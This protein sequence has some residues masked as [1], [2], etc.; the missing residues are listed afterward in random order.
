MLTLRPDPVGFFANRIKAAFSFRRV[1]CAVAGFSISGLGA[2]AL[3]GEAVANG[4]FSSTSGWTPFIYYSNYN[5]NPSPYA[6][7]SNVY[8]SDYYG[9]SQQKNIYTIDTTNGWCSGCVV[10][11]AISQKISL[12]PNTNYKL[13]FKARVEATGSSDLFV[14]IR[15]P[16]G[17]PAYYQDQSPGFVD[18]PT[19]VE[20]RFLVSS[21]LLSTY[22]VY[23]K[24]PATLTGDTYLYISGA[25]GAVLG[26]QRAKIGVADVSITDSPSFT[27]NVVYYMNPTG[28]QVSID[29]NQVGYLGKDK[30]LIFTVR[31]Y[32]QSWESSLA[33]ALYRGGVKVTSVPAATMVGASIDSE[34]GERVVTF[35]MNVSG[36]TSPAQDSQIDQPYGMRTQGYQIGLDSTSSYSPSRILS[37]PF[38]IGSS[39][40]A[41]LAVDA[42]NYFKANHASEAVAPV[43]GRAVNS[44]GEGT[45]NY[46]DGSVKSYGNARAAGPNNDGY[47]VCR[48]G[49]DNF[50]NNFTTTPCTFPN[51][52]TSI[53]VP[54]GWFDAGDQG[55][56]VVNGGVALWTLQNQ[57]ERIQSGASTPVDA[58]Q[59][60]KL[61]D[62]ARY[63][64][65]FMPAM[66]AKPGTKA[67]L[68]VGWQGGVFNG[69]K[70]VYQIPL[71][72][73]KTEN[74]RLAVNQ[75]GAVAF[76]GGRLPRLQIK[77]A[78][79]NEDV[80]GMVFHSVYDESWTS[81]PTAPSANSQRR[82]LSYPTSAATYN[83]AAVAAQCYRVFKNVDVAYANTCKAAALSAWSAAYPRRLAK[84]DI[85]RYEYSNDKW[86][87]VDT[88]PNLKVLENGFG[89][90][91]QWSGGGAYGDLRI[92]DEI[93]WAG[94]ELYLTTGDTQYLNAATTEAGAR[95]DSTSGAYT[96]CG[97]VSGT[98][99]Q[100]TYPV[101]CYSWVNGFDWQ[102]VM[103]L[104][105]LSAVSVNRAYFPVDPTLYNTAKA[106]ITGYANALVA[107][108]NSQAFRFP[109]GS[110]NAAA[111]NVRDLEYDWGSNGSVLNRAIV[112]AI[113]SE[114]Q[115]SKVYGNAAMSA[116]DYI[117]G[118][119]GNGVSYVTGYGNHPA[120]YPHHRFWAKLGN[121]TYP[122]AQPGAL[123]G[124][125][126]SRD[127]AAIFANADH[128]LQRAAPDP[129]NPLAPRACVGG[130][131][132]SAIGSGDADNKYFIEQVASTCMT[133]T[134]KAPQKCFAD[135]PQ[136]FASSEVA[137]NWNAPLTWMATFMT[138]YAN[139]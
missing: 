61:L 35:S 28:T 82:L 32:S 24:T 79:T 44:R 78:L 31:G 126:N 63:E 30:P 29:I 43:S 97:P 122:E 124:G 22:T 87:A 102:N 65:D 86:S 81:I 138:N 23:F 34:T 59:L 17:N 103:A 54:K 91:P 99:S 10:S 108:V 132:E 68:P 46:P 40:F 105:T 3:A 50:G 85:F 11:N 113:T 13:T 73:N 117:L 111:S 123:L 25:S 129:Q 94:M 100:T 74:D 33:P 6:L 47:A 37:E 52:Q 36:L 135:S 75:P 98:Y 58:G 84:T 116:I 42:L 119:N 139:R 121:N 66:Q 56:Y 118:R 15:R 9:N 12:V 38:Q 88:G 49:V 16:N 128:C 5:I 133:S 134:L 110:Y 77:L 27:Q 131:S 96:V 109:K 62:E 95:T 1:I 114:L 90:L 72:D 39:A 26:A 4:S 70:G 20:K 137:I 21:P 14:A 53:P 136:S 83:F 7:Q 55:K 2:S 127:I 115:N 48:G 93:Y 67:T 80:S 41:T 101:H 76:A 60:G 104:G 71:G 51:G 120:Q 57:I 92:N 64:M 45:T 69:T 107:Q 19:L 106:N 18:A 8:L 130:F 125:P 112:L 89:L